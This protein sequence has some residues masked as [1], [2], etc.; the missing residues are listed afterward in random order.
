[1]TKNLTVQFDNQ[2]Y[3]ILMPHLARRLMHTKVI[4]RRDRLGNVSIARNGLALPHR[5]TL[6]H[7]RPH[8]HDGKQLKEHPWRATFSR[9]QSKGRSNEFAG[10]IISE[11]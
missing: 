5:L 8:T 4:I 7:Q 11:S 1:V 2:T 10:D 3:E 9:A 6:T